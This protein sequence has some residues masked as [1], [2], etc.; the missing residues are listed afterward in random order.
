VG[1]PGSEGEDEG[2]GPSEEDAPP[3]A[4]SLDD[5]WRA[6]EELST[7]KFSPRVLGIPDA[8]LRQLGPLPAGAGGESATQVLARAYVTFTTAAE[9][10]AFGGR[11]ATAR[12]EPH[13]ARQ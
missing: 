5:Y 9:R 8:V 4:A 11:E 7:L 1:S 10:R 6:G 2:E 13:S 3:L 12:A